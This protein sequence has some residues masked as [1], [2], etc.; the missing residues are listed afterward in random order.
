MCDLYLI[1]Q[2]FHVNKHI[3]KYKYIY[4]IY[5]HVSTRGTYKNGDQGVY[6][7]YT[8]VSV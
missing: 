4:Y 7:D 6:E 8:E 1:R 5:L 3:P 2:F